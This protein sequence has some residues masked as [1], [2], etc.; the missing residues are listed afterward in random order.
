MWKSVIQKKEGAKQ[1]LK[2]SQIIP[3]LPFTMLGKFS[4]YVPIQHAI[5]LFDD[6]IKDGH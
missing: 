4:R 3:W 5:T 2:L 6:I 1:P